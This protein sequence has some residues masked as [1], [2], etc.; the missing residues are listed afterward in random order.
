MRKSIES[1]KYDNKLYT[2]TLTDNNRNEFVIEL[3]YKP[4]TNIVEIA[5]KIRGLSRVYDMDNPVKQHWVIGHNINNNLIIISGNIS[6][7]LQ[8]LIE[9]EF[10]TESLHEIIIGDKEIQTLLECSR[11]FRVNDKELSVDEESKL[12]DD[13]IQRESNRETLSVFRNRK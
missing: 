3:E 9:N 5:G 1:E 12:Y 11:Q 6:N 7:A 2:I 4:G 13:I 10:I 8:L